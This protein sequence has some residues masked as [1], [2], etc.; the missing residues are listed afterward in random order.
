V[1]T[2]VTPT[3]KDQASD[4]LLRHCLALS[5]D[6]DTRPSAKLRLEEA[7]GPELARMLLASLSLS[8]RR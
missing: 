1:D 6:D 8:R 3:S 5:A 7:V 4:L 2:A